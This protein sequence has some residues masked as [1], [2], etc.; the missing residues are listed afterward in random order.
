M[1][2][3][4]SP[5]ASLADRL[6]RPQRIGVFGHRGVGKTTLLTMLYRE[7]VG[8]RLP[9]L[10]LAA[11]DAR[12]ATYLSDKIQQLEA[13]NAL[14]ATLGETE[15]R[16]H[17][18]SGATRI[19][20]VV[21]DYQ[22]EHVA[23]GRTEPIR[24]FLQQCDAVWLC[25]D[26]PVTG[27]S[28]ARW[29]AEQE[30]EQ[31]VEDYLATERAGEPHRPMALVVTKSDL[32]AD[33][34]VDSI[35]AMLQEQLGMTQHTLN[36]HCPWHDVFAIS[37]L[38]PSGQ[39]QP[40]GLDGPLAWLVQSLRCQDEARLE[41]LWKI[42]S[43]NLAL[44]GRAT[45]TFAR[46]YPDSPARTVFTKRLSAQRWKKRS[47]QALAA[48]AALA[49]LWLGLWSY[50]RVGERNVRRFAEEN[51]DNPEAVLAHWHS[52]QSWH[53][54][55]RVLIPA[56]V[57]AEKED[58]ADLHRVQ[59]EKERDL[60]L[61]DLRRRA[62]DPDADPE[63]VWSD[64]LQFRADF[65]EHDLDGEGRLLRERIKKAS[66]TRREERERIARAKRE[67]EAR[68]ALR[69]LERAEQS[70]DLKALVAQATQLLRQHAGTSAESELTKRRA[71]Y[72]ARIDERDYE[73]ARDYSTRYPNNFYT[74]KQK[75]QEYLDRHPGG[76]YVSQARDA[77]ARIAV[78]WDRHDFRAVVDHY[79]SKPA[80]VKELRKLCRVYLGA[81]PEGKYRDKAT[82]LIRWCD[83]V[84]EPGEYRVTL[85]SGDFS[86]KVAHLVS[87]GASLSVEIEVGGVRYGP[88]SIVKRSYSP[89]WDYEFPRRV[90]W[91]L[92]D[93]VR[94]IVTDNYFWKRKVADET[95]EDELAIR[96]LTGEVEVTYG[97]LTFSCDF[98]M[99]SMPKV[100]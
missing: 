49:A 13:G 18:Y 43:G 74:R 21:L 62:D 5:A 32:L 22:G 25:L 84:S 82:E 98:S 50:D 75:Y 46:R 38:G 83:K 36:T 95:F 92:G 65:P 51:A 16:F 4:V 12:T 40:T 71:R 72:L 42:A 64:F 63:G 79:K 30:V 100:E 96:K 45:H 15:L 3:S 35:P 81:H 29:Q 86:K 90:R 56:A 66:D 8:G 11:A 1:S 44:L 23:L 77:L 31:V 58:L 88:S 59:R 47:R 99:P 6:C 26:A 97:T 60:R 67:S 78:E 91:K 55:R 14:P 48:V 2:R 73:T 70:A 24:D 34:N 27:E 52:Y 20:L 68:S 41:H 54:L 28:S 19:E 39:L 87:R 53:P 7:A 61:T 76:G 89:E 94:V 57:K 17:L 80:D 9:G 10:R 37:S 93:S 69:D 85:K 33:V